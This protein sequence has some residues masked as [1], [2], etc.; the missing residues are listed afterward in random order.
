MKDHDPRDCR[1][2]QS[3]AQHA[4]NV[5]VATESQPPKPHPKALL[6]GEIKRPAQVACC[7][8]ASSAMA[9]APSLKR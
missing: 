6:T 3:S 5:A 4:D 9:T 1:I 7:P 2:S 8:I